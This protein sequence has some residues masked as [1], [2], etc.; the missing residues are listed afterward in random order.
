[1]ATAQGPKSMVHFQLSGTPTQPYVSCWTAPSSPLFSSVPPFP[2]MEGS[3]WLW[4]HSVLWLTEVDTEARQ[5]W[6]ARISI[7]PIG[8]IPRLWQEQGK[9][10]GVALAAKE[11]G[12]SH[13][14]NN[15][16]QRWP[17]AQPCLAGLG[18]AACEAASDEKNHTGT[19]VLPCLERRVGCGLHQSCRNPRHN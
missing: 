12:F 6:L 5:R 9:A 15:A 11:L 1:M 2:H 8:L 13:R 10:E 16:W 19:K 17:R 3:S 14:W 18:A 4:L 7:L